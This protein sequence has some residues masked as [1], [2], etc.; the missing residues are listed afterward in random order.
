MTGGGEP[1]KFPPSGVPG[2]G[3]HRRAARPLC[4]LLVLDLGQGGV[5]VKVG[6]LFAE[7]GADVVKVEGRA[8]PDFM[9][10]MSGTEMAPAFA[11][12]SRSK[13]SFGVNIRTP[14][15]LE[16]VKRLVGYA[17]VVIENSAPG[18]M[19]RLGLGWEAIRNIN[20][21]AVSC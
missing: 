3:L 16:L 13:R 8:N 10:L 12:S 4:G 21:R 19:A 1:W 17:D 14:E 15:G 18:A 11:S 5:G 9:R 6:R 20:P 2:P 7:Y